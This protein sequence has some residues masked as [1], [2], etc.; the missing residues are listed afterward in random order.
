M[1]SSDLA[2]V[3]VCLGGAAVAGAAPV[4]FSTVPVS[5]WSTNGPVRAVLIVGD[6]VYAG[7]DFT[8]VRGPGGS[9]V[10][11]RARLAAWDIRT[12]A[13]RTGFAADANGRVN[14]LASDG[15]R[16]FVGGDFTS[17][18]GVSKARLAAVDP[19]SEIGRAHV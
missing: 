9:P 5:G 7:G 14:A 2:A 17:I 16:L 10:V 18:K 13:L 1:C 11:N 12:G 19:V 6:T 15:S 4:S 8:Q 3:A